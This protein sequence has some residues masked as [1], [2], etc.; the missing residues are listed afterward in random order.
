MNNLYKQ[1]KAKNAEKA[2]VFLAFLY[3]N[4]HY[5]CFLQLLY[6]CWNYLMLLQ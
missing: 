3:V 6:Y 1:E 2:S 5:I 4:E